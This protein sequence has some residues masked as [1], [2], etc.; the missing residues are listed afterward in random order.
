MPYPSKAVPGYPGVSAHEQKGADHW[1]TCNDYCRGFHKE[2]IDTVKNSQNNS[3]D[4]GKDVE[5]DKGEHQEK[6]GFGSSGLRGEF[7]GGI[8][9]TNVLD[10]MLM[11]VQD[12]N[13]EAA[14]PEHEPQT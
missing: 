11:S 3:T 6:D 1:E 5:K 7:G 9:P 14:G 4:E 10:T 12:E 13:H 2:N 8:G